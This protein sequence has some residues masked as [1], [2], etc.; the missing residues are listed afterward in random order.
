MNN[1]RAREGL[2]SSRIIWVIGVNRV[3]R[4][5]RLLGLFVFLELL[6]KD[7]RAG[8]GTVTIEKEDTFY[9]TT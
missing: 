6:C 5:Y 1:T 7:K 3:V 2:L 4:V 8:C 9:T